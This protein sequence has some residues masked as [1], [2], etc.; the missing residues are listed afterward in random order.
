MQAR[1]DR[2][3]RVGVAAAFLAIGGL[4]LASLL[5]F[6]GGGSGSDGSLALA[7][8]EDTQGEVQAGA[9]GDVA[10]SSD[11]AAGG[12][13]NSA[14]VASA[15]N[16]SIAAGTGFGGGELAGE[17]F[18]AAVASAGA[19]ASPGAGGGS[20]SGGVGGSP[21]SA[22]AGIGSPTGGGELLAL[23]GSVGDPGV[24]GLAGTDLDSLVAGLL[25]GSSSSLLDIDVTSDPQD[26]N[27]PLDANAAVNAADTSANL[28]DDDL[29]GDLLGSTLN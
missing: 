27:D 7:G 26:T 11:V 1:R 2:R 8:A 4:G 12:G 19:A 29:L 24:A 18:V 21:I 23:D 5:A 9:A 25:P 6:A 15:V 28:N 14:A 17:T 13:V 3:R 22:S 16:S 20:D 10:L